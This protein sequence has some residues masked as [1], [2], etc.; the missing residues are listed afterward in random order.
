M[1]PVLAILAQ[2]I[3]R[4]RPFGE[5]LKSPRLHTEG[6]KLIEHQKDWPNASLNQA[7]YT[8]KAGASATLSG[9]ALENGQW[10]PGMP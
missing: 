7:G 3:I 6:G 9:V 1:L 2:H 5:A 10:L 4:Q 8:V